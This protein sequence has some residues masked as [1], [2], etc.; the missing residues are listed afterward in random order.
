MKAS[1][2]MFDI[3]AKMRSMHPVSLQKSWDNGG[4]KDNED[5]QVYVDE[6]P[7]PMAGALSAEDVE[8]DAIDLVTPERSPG[9]QETIEEA[10]ERMKPKVDQKTISRKQLSDG[11]KQIDEIE[12]SSRNPEVMK[13][14]SSLHNS[15]TYLTLD[16]KVAAVKKALEDIKE[17][18]R[19]GRGYISR[20]RGGVTPRYSKN[21]VGLGFFDW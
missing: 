11:L 12:S 13:I 15:I 6:K 19:D 17:A 8:S 16:E 14:I 18:K 3:D 21:G 5:N 1:E 10:M 7:E 9:R 20:T 4:D 2:P